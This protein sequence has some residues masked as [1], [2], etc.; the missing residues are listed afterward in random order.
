MEPGIVLILQE[1][2]I[3]DLTSEDMPVVGARKQRVEQGIFSTDSEY[4][5]H[6]TWGF[7]PMVA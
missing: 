5:T 1:E 7:P 6:G 2:V 4:D 3:E